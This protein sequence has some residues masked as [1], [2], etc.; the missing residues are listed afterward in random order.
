MREIQELVDAGGVVEEKDV[1]L[2]HLKLVAP[3][4]GV[5]PTETTAVRLVVL[6]EHGVVAQAKF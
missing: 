2:G 3:R 5:E 4:N 6:D 1:A